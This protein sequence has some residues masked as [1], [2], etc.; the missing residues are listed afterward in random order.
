MR[1]GPVVLHADTFCANTTLCTA[2]ST[3]TS[4]SDVYD[5]MLASLTNLI[6]F[7]QERDSS[8]R[9]LE[10]LI[11]Q[12]ESLIQDKEAAEQQVTTCPPT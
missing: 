11:T 9:E 7:S 8:T 10:E 1:H 3:V 2:I 4:L 6:L 12:M 5:C